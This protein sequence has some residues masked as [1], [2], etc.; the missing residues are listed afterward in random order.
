MIDKIS[1]WADQ[2]SAVALGWL[3]SPAAWSQF[4]ILALSYGMAHLLSRRL[5]PTLDRW[6]DTAA[7]RLGPLGRPLRALSRLLPLLL[8]VLAYGLTAGGEQI[9]RAAFGSGEVIAFGKRVFL[10]LAARIFA[11][12]IMRDPF[13]KV[14]AR[15]VLV[16]LAA[17]YALGVLDETLA[18]L[19]ATVVA[20]GNIRFSL[21]ALLR[22]AVVGSLL[23]WL[24]TW[25]NRQ[26]ADYIKGQN[27]L[28]PATRELFAK[29]AEVVIF[30]TAFVLL[31]SVM[32]ID[33]TAVAVLGG[34]LGVGI[35]L[36]LQQIA[37]NFV[38]GVIC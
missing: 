22:G 12:T 25:S 23:F 32:G 4:A 29:A 2:A 9:T 30:G 14:L 11:R 33:L 16:P 35:G 6:I 19:D 21:L 34:A 26:S 8:P 28:R 18:W 15:Y 24:G 10:Y 13:L 38:S 7:A 17:L 20:L 1:L 31:M 3:T 5:T 36:G 37:A 27:D